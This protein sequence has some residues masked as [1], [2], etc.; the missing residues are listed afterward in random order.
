MRT[1]TDQQQA[2]RAAA[3]VLDPEIPVVTIADLGIL[4]AVK[5]DEAG[6]VTAT[7]T[8]TYSGCPAM[9]AIRSDLECALA[10]A[11]FHAITVRTVLAPAWTTD[12]ITES[13]RKALLEFGI[14][15]PTGRASI[16]PVQLSTRCPHCGSLDTVE[17]SHFSSTACKSL[18]RCRSCA[19]PF[20]SFKVL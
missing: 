7:I 16:T 19:E 6:A 12:W 2:W 9:E 5:V 3:A 4:R 10:E 20:D 14:A 1:A 18:W 15:P 11:G 13:G 8:P 17:V